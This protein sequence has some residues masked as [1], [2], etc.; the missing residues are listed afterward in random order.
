M[1]VYIFFAISSFTFNLMMMISFFIIIFCCW[2]KQEEPKKRWFLLLLFFSVRFRI[3]R[4]CSI[5]WFFFVYFFLKKFFCATKN[6][7]LRLNFNFL[8]HLS[9][10]VFSKF[11]NS[12]SWQF[13]G[14][15]VLWR[16]PFDEVQKVRNR[17]KLISDEIC[18]FFNYFLANFAV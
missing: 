1:C 17:L 11:P 15:F 9:L 5:L 7:F 18:G 13:I 3:S 8:T 2:E 4:S 6:M 12:L 14:R 10:G 16:N